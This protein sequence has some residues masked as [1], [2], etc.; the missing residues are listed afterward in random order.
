MIQENM[1][2]DNQ[3][4]FALYAASRKVV[5]LYTPVLKPLGLTYTQYLVFLVLWEKDGQTVGE[6]CRK[7]YLD[8]GTVTPLLKKMED[9]GY[10]ERRRQKEDERVVSV[11]LTE[12]GKAMQETCSAIPDAIGRC[13]HIEEKD[14]VMLYDLLYRTLGA[15]CNE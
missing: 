5:S 1:R 12:K 6:I 13:V 4:C 11:T 9:A 2:L 8:S 14:A 10:V 7:L 15:V 3:L